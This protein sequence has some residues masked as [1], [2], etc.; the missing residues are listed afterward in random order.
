VAINKIEPEPWGRP[1]NP[2]GCNAPFNDRDP[3]KRFTIEIVVTNQSDRTIP[4]GWYPAFRSS[5]GQTPVTCIW[6]YDDMSVQP[7]ETA[8]ATFATHVE[9]N[10]WVQR[11][12]LDELGYQVTICFN[13]SAQVV[14]CP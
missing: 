13:A 8:Y 4:N 1:T 5:Q 10:D 3:V 2:D 9:L 7:G 6:S 14:V 11:M 12:V